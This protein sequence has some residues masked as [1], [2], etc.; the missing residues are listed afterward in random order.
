MNGLNAILRTERERSGV[1]D[2]V[3]LVVDND[4]DDLATLGSPPRN[5]KLMVESD[6]R[7]LG[8][9]CR[10]RTG[11]ASRRIQLERHSPGNGSIGPNNAA[12]TRLAFPGKLGKWALR[13][14]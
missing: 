11:S 2:S 5:P 12:E 6:M 7:S 4:A 3:F 14:A 9:Y 1:T 8:D 10:C 13:F